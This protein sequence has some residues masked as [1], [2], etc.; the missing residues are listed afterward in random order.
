MKLFSWQIQ[1]LLITSSLLFAACQ[2]NTIDKQSPVITIAEPLEDSLFLSVEPEV[3]VEFTVSDNT[4][5]QSLHVELIDSTQQ[6][7]I[8]ESPDVNGLP[9]Y[10]FHQHVV[11]VLIAPMPMQLRITATDQGNNTTYKII[12]VIISP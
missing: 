6:L 8:N 4:K 7:L 2:K 5:L 11:P 1:S 3:H 9:V 10:P 12:P